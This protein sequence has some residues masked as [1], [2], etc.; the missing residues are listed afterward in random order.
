MVTREWSTRTIRTVHAGREP[1]NQQAS[2]GSAERRYW[3][4]VV[5]RI[6][7]LDLVEEAYETWASSAGFVENRHW[8]FRG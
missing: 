3:A 1:H 8:K 4:T 2:L 6:A 7:A 5:I